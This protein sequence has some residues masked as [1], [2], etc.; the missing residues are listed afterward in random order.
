MAES[1]EPRVFRLKCAKC[2]GIVVCPETIVETGGACADCGQAI[3]IEA[4]PPLRKLAEEREAA[5]AA[6]RQR[7][8]EERRAQREAEERRQ[9]EERTRQREESRQRGEEALQKSQRKAQERE[10]EL[11]RWRERQEEEARTA[12]L[13]QA[14]ATVS[15]VPTYDALRA[16]S[17][18][19]FGF[20]CVY[21]VIGGVALLLAF[22]VPTVSDSSPRGALAVAL[23]LVGAALG[24]A[25]V[26]LLLFGMAQLLAAIRDMAM[27][28]WKQVILLQD[29]EKHVGQAGASGAGA[30]TAA[31]E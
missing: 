2:G 19:L 13:W 20:G 12:A 9:Q 6:E 22:V 26:A 23:P 11:R 28:S 29:V 27:N 30:E 16:T 10:E 8:D 14:R 7:R 4:Y 15:S 1:R 5:R 31:A 18:A 21:A 17:S 24:A 25:V 3:V